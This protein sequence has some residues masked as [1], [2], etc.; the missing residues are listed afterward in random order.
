M[1]NIRQ[2]IA[3]NLESATPPI[4]RDGAQIGPAEWKRIDFCERSRKAK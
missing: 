2:E 4:N 1:V 3:A